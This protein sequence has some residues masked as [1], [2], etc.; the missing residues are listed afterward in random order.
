M[1][2]KIFSVLLFIFFALVVMAKEKKTKVREI[3]STG[4]K[5]PELIGKK[6]KVN[7]DGSIK[8]TYKRGLGLSQAIRVDITQIQEKDSITKANFKDSVARYIKKTIDT[9]IDNNSKHTKLYVGIVGKTTVDSMVSDLS[10][11]YSRL[12]NTLSYEHVPG[13]QRH[14]TFYLLDSLC[15]SY[16]SAQTYKTLKPYKIE[17]VRGTEGASVRVLHTDLFKEFQIKYYNLVITAAQNE[18][19][20]Q[21]GRNDADFKK[22][23]NDSLSG[24]DRDE[25]AAVCSLLNTDNVSVETIK[26]Y[27]IQY[28]KRN[29]RVRFF[30]S[31]WIWQMMWFN[32]GI[33]EV[34]PLP[35]VSD[36]LVP[37][38]SKIS[39]ADS[40][41]LSLYNIYLHD[42][43]RK[44]KADSTE[45]DAD[46]YKKMVLDKMAKA[47][48]LYSDATSH[49]R[50]LAK[51]KQRR[52]NF[53]TCKY[54]E[55]DIMLP[56]KSK[57]Y[58]AHH[59]QYSAKDTVYGNKTMQLKATNVE[60]SVCVTV[61]NV[62][63]GDTIMLTKTRSEPVKDIS[64]ITEGLNNSLDLLSSTV[65]SAVPYLD[66]VNLSLL[67]TKLP[68]GGKQ[69]VP[70]NDI[71]FTLDNNEQAIIS[72]MLKAYNYTSFSNRNEPGDSSAGD[73]IATKMNS[74]YAAITGNIAIELPYCNLP[75][76]NA[77]VLKFNYIFRDS[78]MNNIDAY[79]F[80]DRIK[81]S[82]NQYVDSIIY[83]GIKPCL[84]KAYL[85]YLQADTTINKAYTADKTLPPPI[86][87]L[88][89]TGTSA[90]HYRTA[91]L[92]TETIDSA[93]RW[94]YKVTNKHAVGDKTDTLKVGAFSYRTGKRY[95]LQASIGVTYTGNAVTQNKVS[96]NNGVVSLASTTERYGVA[97][98]IHYYPFNKGV[99]LQDNS[100]LG[101]NLRQF[102]GRMN[103]MAGL[104]F[105]KVPDNLYLGLGY[106][107]GPG[108]KLNVGMH[109]YSYTQYELSNNQI[110]SETTTYKTATPFIY[111]GIDPVSFLKAVSILK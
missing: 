45:K 72:Y 111:V 11:I 101:G 103:I 63:E 44:F 91:V 8:S 15:G 13:W 26:K 110:K 74:R 105:R 40:T 90:A 102:M 78:M 30:Q 53:L 38:N 37:K 64:P 34:N 75:N 27:I 95:R 66:N 12:V 73:V 35:F 16:F 82:L 18:A 29:E 77:V 58:A 88:P 41:Q 61:H 25:I 31:P 70:G 104:D 80:G 33:A 67:K 69:N 23:L 9:L 39:P 43:T 20:R 100:L 24:I 109:F 59:V 96:V 99:L 14:R 93:T 62:A 51:N 68:T 32:K 52:D 89:L 6:I 4:R 50:E 81:D 46:Q 94:N 22:M 107:L 5:E 106:D 1:K 60:S 17:A 85:Q 79:L 54:L 21:Y 10:E 47:N 55:N 108:I 98:A 3:D 92:A 7:K 84:R 57:Y 65:T 97:A 83:N 76:F 42:L 36:E 19:I 48:E 71:D 28:S 2:Q 87:T 56:Y 86:A 49:K